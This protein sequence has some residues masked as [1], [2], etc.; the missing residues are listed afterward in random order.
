L[1]RLPDVSKRYAAPTRKVVNSVR[2]EDLGSPMRILFP[3]IDTEEPKN[4]FSIPGAGLLNVWSK[5]PVLAENRYALP[6]LVSPVLSLNAPITTLSPS[7]DTEFPK[8]SL[9]SGAV[10]TN[11]WSKLPV[12]AENRYALP[13]LVAPVSAQGDPITKFYKS[14]ICII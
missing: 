4:I 12:L 5:L 7:I 13:P 3:S 8:R 1:I 11:V 14:N 6:A 10:L 2:I 9:V